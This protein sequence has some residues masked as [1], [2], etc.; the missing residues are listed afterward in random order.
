[1]LLPLG[2]LSVLAGVAAAL[3]LAHRRRDREAGLTR[4]RTAGLAEGNVSDVA[5]GRAN[6]LVLNW[7]PSPDWMDEAACRDID[8]EAFFRKP[9]AEAL[10]TCAECS[11]VGMCRRYALENDIKYGTWG[12]LTEDERRAMSPQ[13]KQPRPGFARDV[14]EREIST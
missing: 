13:S 6:P 14:A 12:S 10:A 5:V 3:S 7:T 4:I 1:M 2:F 11:V 9:A 8:P